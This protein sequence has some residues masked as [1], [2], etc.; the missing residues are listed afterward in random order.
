M[1]GELLTTPIN[2]NN[3]ESIAALEQKRQEMFEEAKPLNKMRPDLDA[4]THE[5]EKRISSDRN[6]PARSSAK[7]LQ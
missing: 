3:V 2:E 6:G 7:R 1:W 4:R 5:Y